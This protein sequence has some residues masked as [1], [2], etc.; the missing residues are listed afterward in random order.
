MINILVFRTT[1]IGDI[2]G[3]GFQ[4]VTTNNWICGSGYYF[5]GNDVQTRS[6]SANGEIAKVRKG[7]LVTVAV[8]LYEEADIFTLELPLFY[9]QRD[10]DLVNL[11]F[12]DGFNPK[13]NYNKAIESLVVL[14]FSKNQLPLPLPNGKIFEFKLQAK[15][16]LKNISQ[17]LHWSTDRNVE[18]TGLNENILEPDLKIEITDVQP[19]DLYVEV[20]FDEEV[21]E[22]YV[23]SPKDQQVIIQMVN[24]QG[25]VINKEIQMLSRGANH[26]PLNN[27]LTPGI[28]IVQVLNDKQ[29]TW[30]K[31]VI[32]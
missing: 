12:V 21:Q 9:P 7:S 8:S 17:L 30:S 32:Q 2:I 6:S 26:I 31:M 19:P 16:D 20:R 3:S 13:W 10:F 29:S 22:A 27:N 1:K 5:T 18:I 24:D 11:Q 4:E 14:D 15:D 23:E 25:F 28:Y